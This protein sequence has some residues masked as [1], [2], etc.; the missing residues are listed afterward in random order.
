M[1]K[2]VTLASGHEMP[3][4]GLGTWDLRGRKCKRVIQEALAI[5]YTHIDTAWLYKN[6]RAIGDAL[7][8]AGA[9]GSEVFITSKVWHT[10]LR[11]DDVLENA[12]ETLRDLQKEYLD[13]LLIHWPSESIPVTETLRAFQR[14]LDEGKTRSIGVSNFT[15][16]QLEQVQ[17]V[18]QAPVSVNQIQYFPGKTQPDVLRWCRRHNVVVTAY[19]PLGKRRVLTEPVLRKIAAGRRKSAA[20]VALKW[21]LQQG[22][23][24]VPKASSTDHLQENL[25]LF[26]W[27]L[28]DEEMRQIDSL[29]S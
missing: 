5:G 25:D 1:M 23:V 19:S 3:L 16:E 11:Y 14:L 8:E 17:S 28:S 21:L 22:M 12:E 13:L 29:L 4:V 18:S 9:D 24:V 27:E 10:H 15:V 7:R 6:Q 20:Q 26:D 2:T